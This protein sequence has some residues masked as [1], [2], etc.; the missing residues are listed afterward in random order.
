MPTI[1]A[2]YGILIQ[3]Y[4]GGSE[5]PPP[6]FH[7]KHD[8]YEAQVD[9]Q[10]ATIVAGKL[11][12]RQAKMVEVWADLHREELMSNWELVVNHEQPFRIDPLK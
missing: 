8:G 4:W 3:M 5:H 6:H 12:P 10:S 7:A 11:P 9:I 2:F 1:S